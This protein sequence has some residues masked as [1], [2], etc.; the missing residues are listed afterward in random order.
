[1]NPEVLDA[2]ALAIGAMPGPTA[3]LGLTEADLA[4][5]RDHSVRIRRA[6]GAL[7]QVAPDAGCYLSEC[8]YA[9]ADWQRAC[10]GEHW[11][12]LS[13]IKQH[14]DPHGLF[15]VHHGVGS[16]QWSPDGFTRVTYNRPS[17]RRSRW[18]LAKPGIALQSSARPR[19]SGT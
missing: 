4:S 11:A 14:D 6:M 7:R 17:I 12:R 5:A 13:A 18:R 1:M 2:F 19:S 3:Y 8:D 9:L 15:I 10:W 16:E